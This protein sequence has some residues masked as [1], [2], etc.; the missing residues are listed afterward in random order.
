MCSGKYNIDSLEQII[1]ALILC[2]VLCYY[3][4]LVT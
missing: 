1:S 3:D 4:L 2:V